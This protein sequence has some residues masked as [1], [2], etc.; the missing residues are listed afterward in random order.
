[1]D[2]HWKIAG[3]E[4]EIFLRVFASLRHNLVSPLS[5]GRMTIALL[6]RS[7]EMNRID[8]DVLQQQVEKIDQQIKDSVVA[9]RALQMWDSHKN[10][11]G[12]PISIISYGLKLCSSRLSARHI[13]IDLSD[14]LKNKLAAEE[15]H[16]DEV[17]YKPFLYCWLG[18]L[19]FIED[20]LDR[21]SILKLQCK[22]SKSLLIDIVLDEDAAES[23]LSAQPRQITAESILHLAGHYSIAI[24]LNQNQVI[25]EWQ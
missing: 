9:I 6:K 16:L 7:I 17:E 12:N 13:R 24:Q 14:E 10:V 25:F 21:P 5:V 4:H 15:A 18:M 20:N 2:D 23:Q 8:S 22:D 19:C 1:M 11:M 3:I